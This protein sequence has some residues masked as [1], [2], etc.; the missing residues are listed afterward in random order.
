MESKTAIVLTLVTAI[1]LFGL[2]V[3]TIVVGAVNVHDSPEWRSYV[4][5]DFEQSDM[6]RKQSNG[7]GVSM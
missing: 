1:L 6:I 5:F 4:G 7:S 3:F 2:G